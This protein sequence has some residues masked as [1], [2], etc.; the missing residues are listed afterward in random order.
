MEDKEL[1]D[2]R[3]RAKPPESGDGVGGFDKD[4]T[5]AGDSGGGSAG[6]N[7]GAVTPFP[8]VTCGDCLPV[9]VRVSRPPRSSN[10]LPSFWSIANAGEVL[11]GCVLS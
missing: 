5:D 11:G 7:D 2:C 4:A 1:T 3:A 6:G 8:V 10:V 9:D